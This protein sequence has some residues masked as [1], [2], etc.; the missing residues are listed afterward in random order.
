MKAISLILG[1]ILICALSM[2]VLS[3][4]ESFARAGGGHSYSGGGSSGGGGGYSGGGSSSGDGEGLGML[5][6][7]LIMLAIEVP[8]VGIPLIVV[9][10][11]GYFLYRRHRKKQTTKKSYSSAQPKP[12]SHAP[13]QH[14]TRQIEQLQRVDEKFSAPLFLDFAQAVF[15]Q[16][17]MH[18]GQNRLEKLKAYIIHQERNR[19]EQNFQSRGAQ[20]VEQ[21][22]VGACK[23]LSIQTNRN[24]Y[25]QI[26]TRIQANYTILLDPT[27]QRSRKT[28]HITLYVD[29]NWTFARKT[30]V[31][32]KDPEQIATIQCPSCGG[33]LEDSAAETCSYCGSPYE[34]GKAHWFVQRIDIAQ[35]SQREPDLFMGYA[36]ERGTRL[37]TRYQPGL[38]ERMAQFQQAHPDFSERDFLEKARYI[39]QQIQQAWSEQE[40]E[41]ARPF[42]TD[43]LFQTHLYWIT[44]MKSKR[45]YN[46]LEQIAVGKI[47]LVHLSQDYYYDSITIRIYASMIDYMQHHSGKILAGSTKKSR[48]FSEYWTYIRR[49][50]VSETTKAVSTCPNC[51]APLQIGM[52]GK[53]EYCGSKI[54][55][56]EFSWV[57]SRI[58][59]DEEY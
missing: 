48:P 28:N 25:D 43:Y 53:C 20:A 7:F 11:V 47:E 52:S 45:V 57:V 32:S 13:S 39:F 56:G 36:E 59:Q 22:I 23:I 10:V 35:R 38:R 42:E 5:I 4:D 41:L 46:R 40:W 51:G 3:P 9:L 18:A 37:P 19:L 8:E 24:G 14:V 33:P 34:P 6:Y 49:K 17:M 55:T 44:L 29:E 21:V 50:G 54:T 15:V 16:L 58:E 27:S 1:L 30:G 2:I 31:G 12:S 26:K